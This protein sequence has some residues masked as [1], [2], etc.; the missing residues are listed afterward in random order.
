[1]KYLV[2]GAKGQLGQE[3]VKLL[4]EQDKEYIAFDSKQLNIINRERVFQVLDNEK[5]DVV[6]DAA[7]YTAVDAAE[8]EGKK[9]NWLVNAKGT[10]NLADASAKINAKL[11]Y[12]STD[13][14]FSG[15]EKKEYKESDQVNPQNEYGKAKLAGEKAVQD[16]GV[17]YYIIRTS[18]VFGEFGKNFV[19][20]MQNLASKLDKISVVND[21]H[22][23][24]TWTRTLAEFMIYL[25]DQHIEY[26][27]YN[28]SNDGDATWYDFAS[29]ILKYENII[30]ESVTSDKF[31]TRAYRPKNSVLSLKKAKQTGFSIISWH[32]AV[33]QFFKSL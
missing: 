29:E 16:S 18:W 5:P 26:G 9:K 28:L 23:R 10:K 19:Y 2:A 7:A 4:E 12:I 14:V 6:L 8:D 20:T 22:G 33:Q 13:Y 31:P 3:I 11:I 30:I 17:D 15:N 25:V 1:M 27:I 24:P 21:Q 32:D